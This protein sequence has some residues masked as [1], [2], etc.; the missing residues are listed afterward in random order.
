ME[1]NTMTTEE[2]REDLENKLAVRYEAEPVNSEPVQYPEE[3]SGIGGGAVVAILGAGM[4]AGAIAYQFGKKL[5]D[6]HK[7]KKGAK[8]L[9]KAKLDEEFPDD[10]TLNGEVVDG[11]E[12]KAE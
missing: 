1:E 7:A 9:L 8:E 12:E 2:T 6:R 5:W 11:N 4:A 10:E 3:D